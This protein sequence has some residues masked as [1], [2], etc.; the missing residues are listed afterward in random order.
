MDWIRRFTLYISVFS[1]NAGKYGPEKTLYLG[2]F[3]ADSEQK[4]SLVKILHIY[5]KCNTK[6]K[7]LLQIS[8][9]NGFN[10][11]ITEVPFIMKELSLHTLTYNFFKY[12]TLSH[13]KLWINLRSRDV[14]FSCK[15][16]CFDKLIRCLLFKCS[17]KCFRVC[18]T[19]NLAWKNLKKCP[20][21]HGRSTE[22]LA[23]ERIASCYKLL[24]SGISFRNSHCTKNEV[25]H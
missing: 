2:T 15:V 23:T 16:K 25:F 1:R 24:G 8:A 17:K 11:L 4:C 3:H 9:T 13:V 10:Y 5:V 20:L 18:V 14:D 19:K 12:N 6:K 21:I 7:L 22:T